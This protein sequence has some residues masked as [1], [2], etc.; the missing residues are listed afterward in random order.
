M[1]L[2]TKG[3]SLIELVV[4][5]AIMGVIM[6][7]GLPALTTYSRNLKLRAAA[8]SFMACLLYTSHQ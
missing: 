7:L 3:F 6:S 8:E 5:I 1:A 4:A 2:R